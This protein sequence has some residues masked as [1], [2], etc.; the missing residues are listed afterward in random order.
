MGNLVSLLPRQGKCAPA[1]LFGV[2]SHKFLVGILKYKKIQKL[3]NI[4]F[5]DDAFS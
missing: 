3:H 4:M 5:H 1:E 2:S